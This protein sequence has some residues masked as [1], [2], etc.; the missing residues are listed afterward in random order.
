M[1]TENIPG[2]EITLEEL[3]KA[4]EI[5]DARDA[6]SVNLGNLDRGAE[7][8]EELEARLPQAAIDLANENAERVDKAA[9]KKLR[10]FNGRR[11]RNVWNRMNRPSKV[12]K[13]EDNMERILNF[14]GFKGY[15]TDKQ[16]KTKEEAGNVVG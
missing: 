11:N 5:L 13:I 3:K 15:L 4:G 9:K 8:I 16:V 12:A 7:S 6:S 2:T 10:K 1:S 14:C